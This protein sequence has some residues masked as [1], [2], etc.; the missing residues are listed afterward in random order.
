MCETF[1]IKHVPI[2]IMMSFTFQSLNIE[3]IEKKITNIQSLVSQMI[4]SVYNILK[5]KV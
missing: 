3:I 2:M 4:N 1:K 5:L